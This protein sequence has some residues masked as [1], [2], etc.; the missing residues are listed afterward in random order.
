MVKVV[1]ESASINIAQLVGKENGTTIVH[2]YNW[3]E[4]FRSYFKRQAFDGIK[5]LHHLIFE[6]SRRGQVVV[7]QVSDGE[8]KVLN[9][10]IFEDSRRGQVVVKQVSDGEEKVLNVLT[11]QHVH[12]QPSPNN[13]PEE[14]QPPGLSQDRQ[15]YLFEKIREYCPEEVR[16]TDCPDPDLAR[17]AALNECVTLSQSSCS[18]PPTSQSDL[19]PSP[20]PTPKQPS[21]RQCHRR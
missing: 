5:S 3:S 15:H 4:Y 2:Q 20:S 6:D 7:I 12:W 14:I 1:N 10:L 18:S 11:K 21:K 8:E 19:S 16:D 13:L 9:H 17:A